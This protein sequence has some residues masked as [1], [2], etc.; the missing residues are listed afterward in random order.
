M[1]SNSKPAA[2]N[3]VKRG[4]K[5][6]VQPAPTTPVGKAI[7][8]RSERRRRNI[9]I[10]LGVL[11]LANM[12]GA[13]MVLYPPGGSAEGLA[14]QLTTLQA[15]VAQGRQKL[16][17]TRT[18]AAAVQMGRAEGDTFVD[19]YFLG[20]RAVNS[21]LFDEITEIAK[22]TGIRP[23]GESYEDLLIEG[24][25]TLG[26][27][28][29]TANFEGSYDELLNFV[30]EVDRSP[31]LLMIESLNASPQKDDD[32]LLVTVELL[33]F[34]Q[35]QEGFMPAPDPAETQSENGA[36][37]QS[38]D[39][40]NDQGRDQSNEQ[41]NDKTDAGADDSGADKPGVKES[42][43]EAAEVARIVSREVAR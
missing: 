7:A 23:R 31:Q 40:S 30:R 6:G 5:P 25:E 15:E 37:G 33:A 27:R 39:Q 32:V 16:Q 28:T 17:Q 22:R 24:S 21:T 29:I 13:G 35:E 10:V 43:G 26:M 8:G 36:A 12:I 38:S 2:K 20:T 14:A 18:H 19:D 4:V 11:L 1:A 3:A 41:S 42:S 34:T 9:R